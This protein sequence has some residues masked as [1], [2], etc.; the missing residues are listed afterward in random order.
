P[1]KNDTGACG[2]GTNVKFSY[3]QSNAPDATLEV[4]EFDYG[5]NGV[6]FESV[7]DQTGAPNRPLNYLSEAG[8]E[9]I[10][11]RTRNSKAKRAPKEFMDD[12]VRKMR[13]YDD[14]AELTD[15]FKLVESR[16]EKYP[17]HD[18]DTY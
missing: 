10:Q 14:D 15:P 8:D 6:S 3:K 2:S 1:K 18:H 4:D 17:T 12:L 5:D 7:D 11:L 16:V 13:E 9:L